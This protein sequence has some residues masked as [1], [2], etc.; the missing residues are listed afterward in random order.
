MSIIG[1]LAQKYHGKDTAADYLVKKYHY[2]KIAFA[3]PLKDLG[4]KYELSEEEQLAVKEALK[5]QNEN[6]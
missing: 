4:S 2:T 5:S 6:A 3:K 1:F